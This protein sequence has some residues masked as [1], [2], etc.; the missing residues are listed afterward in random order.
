MVETKEV[1]GTL[2]TIFEAMGVLDPAVCRGVA[3]GVKEIYSF[4]KEHDLTLKGIMTVVDDI[5]CHVVMYPI[6]CCD[7]QAVTVVKEF[8]KWLRDD[9]IF[10]VRSGSE[11]TGAVLS[12]DSELLT[13]EELLECC[14]LLANASPE[15]RENAVS[16]MRRMAESIAF[17]DPMMLAAL[18][19][20]KEGYA[21][22][23]MVGLLKEV[24]DRVR[25]SSHIVNC[26]GDNPPYGSARV[27]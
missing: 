4:A 13:P 15:T 19:Q 14:V 3:K 12:T 18:R 5:S 6:E 11:M 26:I 8:I 23:I 2:A 22:V 7:D 21:P 16:S 20:P 24:D 17:S 25:F 9:E 1:I 10:K 27:H